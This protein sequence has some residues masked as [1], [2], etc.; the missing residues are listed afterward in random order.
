MDEHGA[1]SSWSISLPVVIMVTDDDANDTEVGVEWVNEYHGRMPNLNA[2]DDSAEGFY[3]ILGEDLGWTRVFDYGNDAAWEMDF[4]KSTVGGWDFAYVDNVDFALFCGHGDSSGFYFGTNHDGNFIDPYKLD[5][6][7]AEWGDKDLEWIAIATCYTLA[8]SGVYERWGPAFKGLHAMFGY[9]TL[10]DDVADGQRFAE[11]LRDRR[12]TWSIGDC[13]M[14]AT[15]DIQG[16]DVYGAALTVFD[17]VAFRLEFWD[18]LPG[19]GWIGLD[20]TSP[21]DQGLLYYE[22][23][24]C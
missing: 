20:I 3:N 21:L 6:T 4:E 14:N 22:K 16:S 19:Y 15:W 1:T 13:W 11:Y 10:S 9:A 17:P 23:W 7:E 12:E 8:E 2:T 24:Q 18:R 5:H